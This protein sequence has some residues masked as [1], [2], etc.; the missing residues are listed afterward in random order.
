MIPTA[1]PR[2]A[3][4]IASTS[5]LDQA[6]DIVEASPCPRT[7]EAADPIAASHPTHGNNE[8][9]DVTAPHGSGSPA[10]ATWLVCDPQAPG[11]CRLACARARVCPACMH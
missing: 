8:A 2:W 11:G 9:S 7:M 6:K 4:L 3:K 1:A 10:V 5:H